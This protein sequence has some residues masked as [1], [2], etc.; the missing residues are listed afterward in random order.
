MENRKYVVTE[1]YEVI[2]FV[3][4]SGNGGN[5]DS[6]QEM[7]EFV[8]EV[9]RMNKYYAP[10]GWNEEQQAHVESPHVSYKIM[11]DRGRVHQYVSIPVNQVQIIQTAIHQDTV[12]CKLKRSNLSFFDENMHAFAV[13]GCDHLSIET[14]TQLRFKVKSLLQFIRNDEQFLYSFTGKEDV[15]HKA[16]RKRLQRK[17][18]GIDSLSSR[19]MHGI[20]KG[21]A[22]QWEKIHHQSN[23]LKKEVLDS[24]DGW[25]QLLTGKVS[26]RGE[27]IRSPKKNEQSEARL[28]L[29]MTHYIHG[30]FLF[31]LWS[32]DKSRVQV[33]KEYLQR[34]LNGIQGENQLSLVPV[35]PD[36]A[37]LK[38]GHLNTD[39]PRL[40]VTRKELDRLLWIPKVNEIDDSFCVEIEQKTSVPEVLLTEKKGSVPFVRD[41][42]TNQTVSIPRHRNAEQLDDRVKSTIVSG[43]QGSGKT[44]LLVNQILGTYLGGAENA[45]EW[46]KYGRAVIAFDVADG[47]LC[48]QI[49]RCIPD[50]A[51][52]NVVVL[53]HAA[54]DSPLQVGFHDVIQ[55][56]SKSIRKHIADTETQILLDSIKEDGRTV[57]VD[58]FF[59]ASLQASYEVGRGNLVDALNI[60]RD[61]DYLDEIVSKLKKKSKHALV[62]V[63]EANHE[64]MENDSS[65]LKTIRNRIVPYMM[66]E[67]FLN[68][69]DREH[70]ERI[71]FWKWMNDTTEGPYLVLIHLPRSGQ[72]ISKELSKFLFTHY[73]VRIWNLMVAR[74]SIEEEKRKECLVVIDELHQIIDQRAVQDLFPDLFKE[75][76]KFRIRFL[77]T[78]HGWSSFNKAGR[79]EN[80]LKESIYDARPNLILL[81]G[82]SDFFGTME[83]TLSPYKEED[84]HQLMKTP[85]TG[86]VR[87]DWGKQSHV[88][89]AKLLEPAHT[90]FPVYSPISLEKFRSHP[91]KLGVSRTILERKR[92]EKK[93]ERKQSQCK[94]KANQPTKENA[95]ASFTKGRGFRG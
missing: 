84:F 90:R 91:N 9:T 6:T 32:D 74:A 93:Q 22:K 69:I 4:M 50:F 92:Y 25:R 8:K 55:H 13:Q 85:F 44:S 43:E 36:L 29:E 65:V 35:S 20:K 73:F 49:Y 94:E 39:V 40:I 19:I 2:P 7:K 45:E 66:D 42:T 71:D 3:R 24:I 87:Q 67:D 53:N 62:E 34:L 30:E 18:H 60:L 64:D 21:T 56:E 88:F 81:K 14:Q 33:F 76:R 11:K 75:P 54:S 48:R 95:L 51:Q 27:K 26:I 86:I 68:V 28:L 63:L 1:T 23:G 16:L 72:E 41:I 12:S 80:E 57:A 15:N 37:R 70:D 59:K 38:N 77:F 79:K 89:Q 82:G 61:A 58:R 31:I 78:I 46:R 47:N 5:Q 17:L 83:Q 52:S 10:E